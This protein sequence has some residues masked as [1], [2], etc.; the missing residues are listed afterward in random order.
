M[1]SV[2]IS[3]FIQCINCYCFI[4]FPQFIWWRPTFRF[5][6]YFFFRYCFGHKSMQEEKKTEPNQLSLT[7]L[8]MELKRNYRKIHLNRFIIERIHPF[9]AL[10]I[11]R[12]HISLVRV[13]DHNHIKKN[14]TTRNNSIDWILFLIIL[15]IMANKL[16]WFCH[17]LYRYV[18]TVSCLICVLWTHVDKF[19]TSYLFV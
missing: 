8:Q 5:S 10:F 1:W 9:H 17:F 7:M 2:Q 15:I 6:F 13:I 14:R 16:F 11:Q 4:I 19:F 12:E 3:R 18:A